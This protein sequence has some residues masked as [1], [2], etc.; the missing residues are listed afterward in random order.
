MKITRDDVLH[1]ANL[2]R[3]EVD[4]THVDRL[5]E[6][7]GTILSYF[8]TL[9]NV[10]TRDVA[11]TYHAIYS[12]NAFRV[13]EESGPLDR[14]IALANAPEQEDGYFVVPRVIG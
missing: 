8:D 3:L 4:E 1:V 13:D 14:E 11:P 5:V 12:N 7:I 6:Q 9:Q 2:A 10:D